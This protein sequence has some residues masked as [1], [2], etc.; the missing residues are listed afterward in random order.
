M[1]TAEANLVSVSC[2]KTPKPRL[3]GRGTDEGYSVF[4]GVLVPSSCQVREGGLEPPCPLGHTALNRARLPIPP[5]ARGRR[6]VTR[7]ELSA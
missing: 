6:G 5:L 4:Y 2:P 7:G 3:V 1:R